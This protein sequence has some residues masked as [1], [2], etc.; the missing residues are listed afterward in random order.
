MTAKRN[1]LFF[2]GLPFA[3]AIAF[4]IHVY[5]HSVY[6]YELF[7]SFIILSYLFNLGYVIVEIRLLNMLRRRDGFNLGNAYLGMS[8]FKFL[9]FFAAFIPLFKMD[10]VQDRFEYFGFFV[11]YLICLVVGTVYLVS[12]LNQEQS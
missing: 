11:P 6:D 5:L 7:G 9:V 1:K 12:L 4:S 2:L 10:G 3:L 8:M